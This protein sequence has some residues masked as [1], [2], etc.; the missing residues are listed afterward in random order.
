MTIWQIVTEVIATRRCGVLTSG[1]F[2]WNGSIAFWLAVIV[3]GVW[4]NCQGLLLKKATDCSP[5]EPGHRTESRGIP[6]D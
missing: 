3:F 1:P 2:A 5:P 6:H 4:L